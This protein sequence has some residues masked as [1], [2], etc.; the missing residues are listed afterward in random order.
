M[1]NKILI[2]I[3]LISINTHSQEKKKIFQDEFA[4][5]T[6]LCK[7]IGDSIVSKTAEFKL[8]EWYE[9]DENEKVNANILELKT[10]IRASKLNVTYWIALMHENPLIYTIH[11]GNKE[12]KEEFGQLFF[13]FINRDNVLVDKVSFNSKL[14]IKKMESEPTK[15][16]D[17]M[18]MRNATLPPLPTSDKK[19]NSVNGN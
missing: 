12:T 2:L 13:T 11:F 1:K 18:G 17:T 14:E 7:K 8:S 4:P 3:F 6:L 19:T 15:P 9:G 10:D 16:M 5:F